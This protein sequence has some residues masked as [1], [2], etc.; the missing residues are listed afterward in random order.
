MNTWTYL[1]SIAT[2]LALNSCLDLN[3]GSKTDTATQTQTDTGQQTDT[4]THEQ[5][6]TDTNT[7]TSSNCLE[8][9]D[10]AVFTSSIDTNK[11]VSF[12]ASE[13]FIMDCVTAGEIERY[14][15]DFGDGTIITTNNP[16]TIHTYAAEGQFTVT[17]TV[18]S[19]TTY[20]S[21]TNII[22]VTLDDKVCIELVSNP[23][24][25]FEQK[26]D[27]TYS[28]DATNSFIY[29]NCTTSKPSQYSWNFGDGT[30][31][32]TN[33]PL[34]DY[35]F[36][37]SGDYEVTLT[38]MADSSPYSQTHTV[39]VFDLVQCDIYPSSYFESSIKDGFVNFDASK[40]KVYS[41]NLCSNYS[42]VEYHWDFGDG[43]NEV[44]TDA[45][46]A[47]QYEQAGSY[48]VVLNATS[49]NGLV[50][51][52]Y[53]TL[54][55]ELTDICAPS[56]SDLM[57]DI[58]T[59]GGIDVDATLILD[60]SS[61]LGPHCNASEYTWDFGDGTT[62]TTNSAY[63]THQYSQAGVYDILV[64]NSL[65]HSFSQSVKWN[66]QLCVIDGYPI[67]AV[68]SGGYEVVV[69][70]RF[71]G[72]ADVTFTIEDSSNLVDQ[73]T[74]KWQ[75]NDGQAG[76]GQS[77][78]AIFTQAGEF[79][80]LVTVQNTG[81]TIW[82]N[83]F[84][85]EVREGQCFDPVSNPRWTSRNQY[86]VNDDWNLLFPIEP[87][88]P[89]LSDIKINGFNVMFNAQDYWTGCDMYVDV[90]WDFG[91]GTTLSSEH[92][93][94]THDYELAGEYVVSM[95]VYNESYQRTIV[96]EP[97][98]MC[99]ALPNPQFE[100]QSIDGLAVT[101]DARASTSCANYEYQ[102][103]FGDGNVLDGLDAI[104]THQYQ[105]SGSYTV[106]LSLAGT[107]QQFT[108]TVT[109]TSTV[110][111]EM[112]IT[113]NQN[114][115]DKTVSFSADAYYLTV[116]NQ[117]ISA[118]LII[119]DPIPVAPPLIFGFSWDFGD[120]NQ[121]DGAYIQH[122]YTQLGVYTVTVTATD[123]QTN[124]TQTETFEIVIK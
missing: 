110:I 114:I 38:I 24:F 71:E 44:T 5:T 31:L 105:Q 13:S 7:H 88:E 77:F 56:Q 40:T 9:T 106:S 60:V 90:V 28:F 119:A 65:G 86:N 43:N 84:T 30:T 87:P 55:V 47:H 85:Y 42:A 37:Q 1:L 58:D 33:N 70:P 25:V 104:Q 46:I 53:L 82:T 50:G 2:V 10:Y 66:D 17:L 48:D 72:S 109:V 27:Q 64:T 97:E 16:Q 98:I 61:D 116:V 83:L 57:F 107:D 80:I 74:Y 108:Q 111:S 52:F 3:L 54:D 91:D 95:S 22:D 121:G 112:V 113:H 94:I 59:S 45:L 69:T 4:D 14:Q 18:S 115:Q 39:S 67:C 29:E 49:E 76:I 51:E 99:L 35:T 92:K 26:S 36:T 123:L 101:F 32:T 75:T 120:Q 103:N 41:N 8:Q 96:I 79:E 124:E 78:D 6:I 63:V 81:N 100:I 12:D 11:T 34:V 23:A 20:I 15:W 73:H 89:H 122:T 93:T 62:T 118:R 68:H 21:Y 102:W 117:G 19:A